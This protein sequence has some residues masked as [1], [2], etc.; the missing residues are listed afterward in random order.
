MSARPSDIG[1]VPRWLTGWGSAADDGASRPVRA[2]G[3]GLLYPIAN[4]GFRQVEVPRYGTH[5]LS[6]LADQFHGLSFEFVRELPS[7][8]SGHLGLPSGRYSLQRGVY[9][10]G[11]GSGGCW[12]HSLA[13]SL[14][15]RDFVLPVRRV[16]F[17]KC[18]LGDTLLDDGASNLS[19]SPRQPDP[20][21]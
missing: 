10:E 11:T 12:G 2:G 14:L 13:A 18:R 15:L 17:E 8:S 20:G 21:V 9:Q 1:S 4:R 3:L 16:T 7:T 6:A 5:A 19:S